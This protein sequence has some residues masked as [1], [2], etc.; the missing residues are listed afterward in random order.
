MKDLT[1]LIRCDDR[2]NRQPRNWQEARTVARDRQI[3]RQIE[4]LEVET[5]L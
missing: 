2:D 3:A 4:E 5:A 1:K